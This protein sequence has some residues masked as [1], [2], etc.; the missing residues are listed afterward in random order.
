MAIVLFRLTLAVA[1]GLSVAASAWAGP[2]SG[3]SNDSGNAFDPPIAAS[4]SQF[5]GWATSVVQ[6]LPAPGVMGNDDASQTLGSPDGVTVSLGD[7]FEVGVNEPPDDGSVLPFDLRDPWSGDAN[8]LADD[9]GFVGIDGPGSITVGFDVPIVNITGFDFAVFENGF[10]HAF[11]S[12]VTHQD[13]IF[14][15]LGHVEVSSDGV[16]FVRFPSVSTHVEA[17]LDTEY[18]REFAALDPTNVL[19]LAGKHA[20]GWA[21]QF[22]LAVLESD[23]LVTGSQVDLDGVNFVRIVDIVGNGSVIDASSNGIFDSWVGVNTGGF[24]LD[25]V[26]VLPEPATCLIFVFNAALLVIGRQ[27]RS[28]RT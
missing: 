14:A 20:F 28:E 26:G 2:Y 19:H 23:P 7:L 12:E 10:G 27:R 8:D 16:N 21:T 22:D 11:A 6:Y 25:A 3:H 15:E 13:Y 5:I 17:D 9:Y 4:D 18:G 24:D 1:A